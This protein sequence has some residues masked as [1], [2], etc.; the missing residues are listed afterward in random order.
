MHSAI[1]RHG[2]RSSTGFLHLHVVVVSKFTIL[3]VIDTISFLVSGPRN[4]PTTMQKYIICRNIPSCKIIHVRKNAQPHHLQKSDLQYDC[5]IG[6]LF[7]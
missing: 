7:M 5:N 2:Y 6:I 1:C 4:V 3:F